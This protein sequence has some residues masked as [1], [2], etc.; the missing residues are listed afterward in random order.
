MLALGQCHDELL[1]EG[2]DVLI[3]DNLAF[4]FL[5][6]QYAFG[7]LDGHIA[8]YFNL[9]AQTPV[10]LLLLA[11]EVR[12]FG[13]QDFATSFNDLALA[14]SARTLATAG[15]RQEDTIDRQC[16]EQC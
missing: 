4:P 5:H 7:H 15:R 2:S 11:A 9:T 3:G 1:D 16:V 8:F 10:V 6:A 13:R 14:L 12:Y